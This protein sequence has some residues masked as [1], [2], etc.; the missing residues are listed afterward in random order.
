MTFKFDSN[1]ELL[2]TFGMSLEAVGHE[3]DTK[4]LYNNSLKKVRLVPG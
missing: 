2:V 1:L 3:V 4:F